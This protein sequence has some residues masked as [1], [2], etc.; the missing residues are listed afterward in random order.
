[1]SKL[2]KRAVASESYI[3]EFR[4][5]S[6]E[7]QATKELVPLRPS[8]ASSLTPE[9]RDP[10]EYPLISTETP[11]SL[12][13][14]WSRMPIRH[15][16]PPPRTLQRTQNCDDFLK[17]A[18]SRDHSFPWKYRQLCRSRHL[19]AS[20]AALPTPHQYRTAFH[21]KKAGVILILTTHG[22]HQQVAKW[23]VRII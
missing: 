8:P 19:V 5:S 1:M 7:D 13:W 4:P 12:S 2:H 9:R 22:V 23:T 6:Q 10:E 18:L 15:F 16:T 3:P 14:Q 21:G 17:L 20:P 11:L